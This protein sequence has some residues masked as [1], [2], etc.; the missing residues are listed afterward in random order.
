MTM[1]EKNRAMYPSRP[2][3]DTTPWPN[4]RNTFDASTRSTLDT[5]EELLAVIACRI[6][7]CHGTIRLAVD[8]LA[9]ERFAGGPDLGRGPFCDNAPLRNEIE[10][11]H[12][13]QRFV[14][15]VGH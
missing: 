12:D 4:R 9:H 2:M 11:I 15:V 10:V 7:E 14:H 3:P 1:A 8:E 6:M 13:L 5:G